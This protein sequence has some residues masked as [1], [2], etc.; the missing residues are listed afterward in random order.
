METNLF[1]IRCASLNDVPEIS[2]LSFEAR[3]RYANFPALEFVAAAPPIKIERIHEDQAITAV[4]VDGAILG[5]ALFKPLDQLMFLDNISV[6][7]DVS[8]LGVGSA[9]LIKVIEKTAQA[10]LGHVAL[11]TFR[12]PPWNGTWFRKF[13]FEMMPANMIGGGLKS[14]IIRQSA[15]VDP[16]TR[17]VL[18]RAV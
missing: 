6:A 9:L 16:Q 14:V 4:S 7:S 17:E 5:F 12:V 2:R 11:T 10:R 13:D 1:N 8:G 18:W 15:N 3:R